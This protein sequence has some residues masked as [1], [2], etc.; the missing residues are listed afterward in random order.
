MSTLLSF[1]SLAALFAVY[2]YLGRVAVSRGHRAGESGSTY[3][4]AL[5]FY[6]RVAPFFLGLAVVLFGS[7]ATWAWAGR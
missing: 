5:P 2:G 1:A 4:L 3:T 6:I 7:A